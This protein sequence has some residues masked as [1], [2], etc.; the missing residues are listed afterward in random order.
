MASIAPHGSWRSPISAAMV[1]S[2]GVGL[3]QVQLDGED[4]YWI[5]ARPKEEGRNVV[6]RRSAGG[7]N[8][9]VTPSGFDARNT[10]HEYGGG[11]YAVAGGT[12]YFSNFRD[13]RLYRQAAG[14]PPEPMTPEGKLRY[15]DMLVDAAR[16]RLIC[17]REDHTSSDQDCVNELVAVPLEGGAP[18]VLASGRDFYGYATLS[19]QGDRLAWLEWDH[20]SMPWDGTELW[21]AEVGADGSLGERRQVAG[22]PSESI[23]QPAW[24]PD[25]VLHFASDRTGWWNLY[26]ADGGEAQAL[27]R[28]DAEFG[29]PQWVFGL[30]TYAFVTPRRLLCEYTQQGIWNLAFLDLDA[31]TLDRIELPFSDF[32]RP[33]VR[34]D[35]AFLLAAGPSDP[36]S[37]IELDL[38]SGE[39]EVLKRSYEQYVDPGFVSRPEPIEFETTGGERAY[40]FYYPPTNPDFEAPGEEPPLL[41]NVHG[42]PTS[43]VA[44]VVNFEFQWFTSRGL[45]V[46]DLNYRGSTGYGRRYRELLR[47]QWGVADVDDAINA[48]TYL[49]ERGEADARRVSVRGGSAG[50]YT[51]LAALAFR[52]YFQAGASY[53]GVSDVELLDKETHKFESRYCAPLI[54]GAQNYASRSPVHSADRISAPLLVLQGLDDHVVPPSQAEA[55]VASLKARR[56]PFAYITFEGEGH[57]FRRD[58]NVRRALEAEGYFYSRVFGFDLADDVEPVEIENLPG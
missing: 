22:G 13:Q 42:G 19:Q 26:R 52:A 37:V 31:A 38:R 40:G 23:F 35:R 53:F 43:Q 55:I 20:P 48:A 24:S 16:G 58:A 46:V 51:T 49:V 44:A 45:G 5:E 29:R 47:G 41:V 57:G 7:E 3:T 14:G 50:G 25:G 15:A 33:R 10:V 56:V 12:V 28:L 27:F 54:G 6:V 9:E 36:R 2:G 8:R 4:V 1:A 34:V 39:F 11:D 17:V 32:G 18:T 30:G 21:T